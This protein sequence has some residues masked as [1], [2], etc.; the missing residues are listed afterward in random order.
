MSRNKD[1]AFYHEF[2]GKPY[3]ECRRIMKACHW[4][5]GAAI[6][7]D[8]NKGID[9]VSEALKIFPEIIETSCHAVGEFLISLGEGLRG[10]NLT[11]QEEEYG[12]V[13]NI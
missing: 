8:A 1:I 5:L 9:A 12:A 6:L 11:D 13:G 7:Y 10:V 4:E 3:S 2:T